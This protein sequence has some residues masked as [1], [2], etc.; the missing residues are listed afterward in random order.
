MSKS[1][2]NKD[3]DEIPNIGHSLT[4]LTFRWL[5]KLLECFDKLLQHKINHF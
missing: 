4:N 3:K 5:K 1:E 2:D